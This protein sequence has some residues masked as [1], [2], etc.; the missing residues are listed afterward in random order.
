M[1][2]AGLGKVRLVIKVKGYIRSIVL[3]DVLYVL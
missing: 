2:G 1:L 3:M